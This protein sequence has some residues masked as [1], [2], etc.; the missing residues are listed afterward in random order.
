M[1]RMASGVAELSGRDRVLLVGR[2]PSA[3]A[4]VG[5]ATGLPVA[6]DEL[7]GL[8]A[9][10]TPGD[11]LLSTVG[12]FDLLGDQ[13]VGAA[14][15]SAVTYVDICAEPTFLDRLHRAHGPQAA[16][17]GI[18][19]LPAVG[20][21][22]MAGHLVADAALREAGDGAAAV[23]I[24]YL[25]QIGPEPIG[26]GPLKVADP[27]S[28]VRLRSGSEAG[29]RSQARV[30]SAPTWSVRRGRLHREPVGARLSGV[31]DGAPT[32]SVG[33][34]RCG[35]CRSTTRICGPSTCTRGTSGRWRRR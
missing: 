31:L 14:L 23:T 4:E 22:S 12:P 26:I 35:A 13:V 27:R 1:L 7:D 30:L 33:G 3:L 18:T 21:R 34:R 11:V 2:H 25:D 24:T 20:L 29:R 16:T 8:A 15:G 17:Y 19:L 28:L 10:L 9:V 32:T 5:T 6:V